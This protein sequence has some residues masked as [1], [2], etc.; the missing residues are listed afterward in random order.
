MQRITR[1]LPMRGCSNG[2]LRSSRQPSPGGADRVVA[3]AGIRTLAT[4]FIQ[5]LPVLDSV[6]TAYSHEFHAELVYELCA[7]L[8]REGLVK[9]E[10]WPECG[11]NAQV[12]AQRAIMECIGEQRW[13][14]LKR[15]VEY[16]LT[17]S[18]VAERDGDDAFLGN[19]RLA[20]T[21]DCNGAGY[22]KIG[23]ALDALEEEAEGLGA[24][25]Y[26]TL[27]YA[28]Y[29]VMR[30]YNHDDALQ[31]EER[32]KEYAEDDGE[33]LNQYE[34][35][36]VDKAVPECIRKT[37]KCDHRTSVREAR[38]LLS[39]HRNGRYAS[40]IERLRNIQRLARIPFRTDPFFREDG[41]YD[42]IPLPSL[43][44]AFKEQD[45]IVACF[46]E[47]GQY[48][49]EGSSEPTLG[50][51]FNPQK[52]DEVRLAVHMVGRFVALNHELFQL[53]EAIQDWEKCD[54]DTRLNW[55]EPAIRA[56]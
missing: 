7:A 40:W 22:L 5:A 29:R 56:A 51:I 21:I 11:E 30:I 12:F 45:A 10:T 14:L 34:F 37:L 35:P 24:A 42:S 20:L 25:F 31:Y 23:P 4:S 48:M 50:V 9:P 28:L 41:G 49:L 8:V 2:P 36:E 33:N 44:V 26:L 53:V 15:N 39:K 55:R 47:E 18:D 54:G 16:H 27:T 19:G 52:P 6:P 3:S 46:D 17:V 38:S 1:T 43:V 32:M 13:N